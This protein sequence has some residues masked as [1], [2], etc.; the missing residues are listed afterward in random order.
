MKQS[1]IAPRTALS[2]QARGERRAGILFALPVIFGV[3]IYIIYPMVGTAVV[4]LTKAYVPGSPLGPLTVEHYVTLFTGGDPF[5]VKSILATLYYVGITVPLSMIFSYTVALML[6]RNIRLRGAFRAVYYVPVVIPLAATSMVWVWLLN[7]NFGIFN[8][9]LKSLGLPISQFLGSPATVVPTLALFALWCTGNTVVIFL[10]SLQEVPTSLYEAL[11]VDG[12]NFVHKLIYVTIP[13]T[14]PI[15]FFN[16]LIAFL[17]TLQTFVQPYMMTSASG[18]GS[19]SPGSMGGPSGAS[20][21]YSLNI[22]REAFMLHNYSNA[23]ALS[24]VL[25][26]VLLIFT[27]IFFRSFKRFVYYEGG[28]GK[29]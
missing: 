15:I 16:T 2:R 7:P 28:D 23:A 18:T 13:M 12:G 26:V 19:Q 24:V 3:L 29:R 11:E 25:I 21:F 1:H 17:N 22:Y 4:S 10:A 8:S 6:S 9:V 27:L 5:F 14:S 20:L